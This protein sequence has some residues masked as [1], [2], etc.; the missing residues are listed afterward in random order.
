MVILKERITQE[1]LPFVNRPGQYIGGEYNQVV[2]DW[3][4][5]SIK[6]AFLFPDTYEIGMSFVGMRI[7]YHVVNQHPRFLLE[8]SFAPLVDMEQRMREKGIPLF[9]WESGRAIADFDVVGFTLQYEMSYS[10]ILNMLDLAG[11]P[12]LAKDRKD[13]D[14]LVVGGGPGAFNPEPIADFFDLFMLG[15]GEELLPELLEAYEAS[16]AAGETKAAFLEKAAQIPGIYVPS[17]YQVSYREDSTIASITPLA[18]APAVVYKRVL[19]D[20]DF[21]IYPDKDLVPLTQVV[22]DRAV[23][24]VM[25]GCTRGCRFCQAGM[26]YRP[27]REKTVDK[28]IEQADALLENSGY[29]EIGVMS[30]STADYSCVNELIGQL[31]DRYS[32]DGVGVSLPSLRVDAFSVD[33]AE[34]VQKVRKSGLTF[35]PEAGTQRMRNVI[36]KG[37]TEEHVLHATK[38]AFSQGWTQIKL[39]FMIGLPTETKED[40]DGI[41]DLAVKVLQAGKEIAREK[42]IRKQLKV[43]VSVSSF[44]PKS[45]TPFQWFGQNALQELKEKQYYLKDQARQHKN[46]SLSYHQSEVSFLE[47]AFSRGDRRLSRVL[48]QAW[49]MGCKFDG[50]TEHFKY[51]TWLDAFAF[52]GYTPEFFANREFG[53]EE[54]LPW[55]HLSAG[56]SQK[57][58]W[59]E[60]EKAQQEALTT[61]CRWNPCSGCG[62]CPKLG[63]DIDLK[64]ANK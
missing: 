41:I 20:M 48:L 56:V 23:L 42:G 49:Q 39:Y 45:H 17:L 51:Q 7:L 53:K 21:A 61:D 62:V 6:M 54:V 10:N 9:S 3:D 27:V 52:C 55:Q 22:H 36:N 5:A 30:L 26:I 58:L 44:V 16:K 34:K 50:W 46:I 47:A 40:L 28:L 59:H 1:L 63:V 31:L 12:L 8:R 43:S 33:L 57:W 2:K 19:P 4:S 18:N 32:K 64:G 11:I 35:A 24:E 15:E 38:S 14:P 37:V 60:W 29:E 13:S 25:R